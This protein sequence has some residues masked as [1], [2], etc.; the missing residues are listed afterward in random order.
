[1]KVH[2][3]FGLTLQMLLALPAHAAMPDLTIVAPQGLQACSSDNP[4]R[5]GLKVMANAAASTLAGCFQSAETIEVHD[6][7]KSIT[8]PRARADALFI[9]GN[10]DY[11]FTRDDFESLKAT[12]KSQWAHYAP[13]DGK[14]SK[15]HQ[16]RVNALLADISQAQ[17]L[18]T[19][20]V[21][22]LDAPILVKFDESVPDRY[23]VTSIRKRTIRVGTDSYTAVA[24]ES[25][26]IV[27]K[28]GALVRL[29]F[30]RHLVQQSDID[31]AMQSEGAWV[32]QVS[33][34]SSG[35]ASE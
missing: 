4:M 14:Q 35:Q 23:I 13:K 5:E 15:K 22:A 11:R 2:T 26:A 21:Q 32:D 25:A 9:K 12:I 34:G 18:P 28:S 6:D 20:Q 8:V 31:S 3:L 16:E 27:Y 1:M 29:D 10:N 24:V 33:A 19:A 7:A 30:S 17:H